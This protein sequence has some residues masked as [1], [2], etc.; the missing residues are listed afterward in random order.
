M[1]LLALA[2]A[3][4]GE[5]FHRHLYLYGWMD[6]S[7]TA[8]ISALSLCVTMIARYLR[9]AR[10]GPIWHA[11]SRIC[12]RAVLLPARSIS[13]YS[14]NLKSDVMYFGIFIINLYIRIYCIRLQVAIL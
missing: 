3:A 4:A 6:M 1:Q 7:S 14:S 10:C 13:E 11:R 8:M 2:A 9:R 12:G 5:A